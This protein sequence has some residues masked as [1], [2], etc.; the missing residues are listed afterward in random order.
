MRNKKTNIKIMKWLFVGAAILTMISCAYSQS[1]RNITEE[2]KEKGAYLFA[3]FIGNK[4]NEETVRFA[5]SFD[6]FKYRALNNNEPVLD[7]KEISSTGGVRDPH[8][9]RGV[10]GNSFY[11]VL[12]D[13]TSNKGWDSNRAMVLLKSNDLTNWTS[14]VVNIQN[15]Y[16]GQENLKRVWAP[17]TVYDPAV[18]KYMIYWS[19]QHGNGP[20]I[21]YYAYA[22]DDFTGLEGDPKVL[23]MPRNGKACIDGDI[24]LKNGIYHLFYKTEGHGNGIRVALTDSLGSDRWIEQ[25]GYK[26]QT[27]EAVEGSSIFKLNDSN[28]YIMMYDVYMK[29]G[30]E[31]CES[32]DLDEFSVVDQKVDMNFHPRHGSVI[33]IS[34]DEFQ[35]LI[36]KWGMPEDL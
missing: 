29:G 4:P 31:F 32:V 12:T 7:S 3:Y 1:L 9:L 27:T 5:V 20:D 11:M 28:S 17:Q 23:F 35:I 25:P 24:V 21:I 14:S 16:E 33:H 2:P 13:M 30:Y 34:H 10:D 8:I 36:D 26:Q 18:N 15:E 19:M 6:G 22:N